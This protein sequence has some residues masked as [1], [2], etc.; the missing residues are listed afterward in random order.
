MLPGIPTIVFRRALEE[1]GAD[2][3]KRKCRADEDRG[4]PACETLRI[5][6]QLADV[7][8]AQLSRAI[9]DLISGLIDI[10]GDRVMKPLS[11]L[12]GSLPRHR[13]NR[14]EPVGGLLLL[15]GE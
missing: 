11:P 5:V 9:F 15:L 7:L 1:P 8:V 14:A 10:T 6:E 13:R 12:L 4:P 2:H 3:P